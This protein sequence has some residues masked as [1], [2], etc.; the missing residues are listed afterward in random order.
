MKKMERKKKG[1]GG[2]KKKEEKKKKKKRGGG[3]FLLV[4]GRGGGGGADFSFDSFNR[5]K[6]LLTSSGEVA[7]NVFEQNKKWPSVAVPCALR[8]TDKR[9]RERVRQ[10]RR[11]AEA[12]GGRGDGPASRQQQHRPGSSGRG[13]T[14]RV[15]A[16]RGGLHVLGP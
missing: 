13:C 6:C 9:C 16:V 7:D 15:T 1:W 3:C 10:R 14:T 2:K 11:Q 8:V 12:K 5:D 4:Y